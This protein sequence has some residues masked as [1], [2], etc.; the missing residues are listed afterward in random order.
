VFLGT[1]SNT[2]HAAVTGLQVTHRGHTYSIPDDVQTVADLQSS[3]S[4][5]SGQT[6]ADIQKQ[7][8]VWNDQKLDVHANLAK[9]GV[10][11]GDLLT[12]VSP[13]G[14]GKK[15]KKSLSTSTVT[16]ATS[17]STAE[18]STSNDNNMDAMMKDYLAKSGIDSSQ[19][20][21]FMKSMG[22][23][24]GGAGSNGEQPSM[25]EAMQAMS[26]MM[27]SPLFKEFMSDPEKLE[28]SRQMI[29]TNPM[30]KGMMAGMPG[31]DQLLNSK[32]AWR[33][34]MM[35]AATMYQSMDQDDL[36]KGIM[37]GLSGGMPPSA[38]SS[39][40]PAGLFDGMT[41]DPPASTTTAAAALEELDEED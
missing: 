18:S 21:D 32:E 27:N 2:A 3:M 36:M 5:T 37:S 29:L 30:L 34:A 40:P 4:L 19:L 24:G 22:G 17:S 33:E 23:L 10:K 35:A 14:S 8:V 25:Q 15:K 13:T 6:L 20:D 11:E 7:S 12:L 28:Q 9:V 16:A 41:L 26:G 38:G 31:M 1:L 39:A